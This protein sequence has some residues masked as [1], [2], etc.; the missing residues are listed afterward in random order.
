MSSSFIPMD[1]PNPPP[2]AAASDGLPQVCAPTEPTGAGTVAEPAAG[3][4]DGTGGAAPRRPDAGAATTANLRAGLAS[5]LRSAYE[6]GAGLGDLAVASHQSISEVRELLALAATGPAPGQQDTVPPQRSGPPEPSVEDWRP[7]AGRPR[8]RVRRQLPS[9]RSARPAGPTLADGAS[10]EAGAWSA[11]ELPVAG[12]SADAPPAEARSFDPRP[13]EA[14]PSD[15]RPIEPSPAGA[16]PEQGRQDPPLGVLIGASR[17]PGPLGGKRVEECRKRVTAQLVKV[18]RGTTLAVLPAWRASIAVSVPTELLLDE[19]G[20]A[21][22]ELAGTELTVVVNTE[23]LH[24]REL[25]PSGW[26]V[27]TADRPGGR[28]RG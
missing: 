25:R 4:A 6:Q 12:R 3:P 13:S 17:P 2:A 21:F 8:P 10:G 20:L 9:R 19:T 14:E 15:A 27:V 28:R 5:R 24:D 7:T 22:E 1:T 18:G 11:A 16:D 26:Q 23:A